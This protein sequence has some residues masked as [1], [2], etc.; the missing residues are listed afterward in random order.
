MASKKVLIFSVFALICPWASGVTDKTTTV[1]L[2]L[3][4]KQAVQVIASWERD[5]ITSAPLLFDWTPDPG[6]LENYF[7]VKLNDVATSSVTDKK[8]WLFIR[9]RR[10]L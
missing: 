6:E 4:L 5:E 10:S 8:Y 3:E 7:S 9:Q 2:Q 1:A